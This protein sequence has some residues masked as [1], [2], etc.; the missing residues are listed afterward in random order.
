[1]G[2]QNRVAGTKVALMDSNP[3]GQNLDLSVGFSAIANFGSFAHDDS[4]LL[5]SDIA[6]Q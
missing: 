6:R 5:Q 1:M 2:Q 3:V 4:S